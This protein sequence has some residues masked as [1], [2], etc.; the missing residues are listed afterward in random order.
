V[1]IVDFHAHIYPDKIAERAVHSVGDFYGVTMAGHEGT[2]TELLDITEGTGIANFVVHSVA[3]TPAQVS[4]IN[5]FIASACQAHPMFIGFGTLHPELED[6]NGALDELQALGL[7]G[8]KLHPDTQ[9]FDLDAP[10]MMPVYAEIARRGLPMI[11]HTGDY[12]HDWSHPRRMQHVLHEVPDLIVDAAHF[13]GWSVFDLALDYLKD[14]SCFMDLSSSMCF[15]GPNRTRELI[16]IYGADRILFGSDFPM[17]SPKEEL[18]AFRALGLAP[19]EQEKIL[20][21]NAARILGL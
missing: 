2:A 19:I 7:R 10:E 4:S 1:N 9:E 12:R 21:A 8:V 14:E 16:E 18:A 6:F 20:Y 13:G 3:T 5:R 17:W 11:F 15:L